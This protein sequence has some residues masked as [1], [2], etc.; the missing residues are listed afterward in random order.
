MGQLTIALAGSVGSG[1]STVAQEIAQRLGCPV[2]G[3]G[4]Y[5]RYLA[6]EAGEATDRLSLQRLGQAE[7][8]ADPTNFVQRFLDWAPLVPSRSLIIDGVRHAAVDEALR[9]WARSA[10]REYVLV[11]LDTPV[12][13]RA[14]R[15]HKGDEG[16]MVRTD[17]HPVERETKVLLPDLADLVVDGSGTVDEVLSRIADAAPEPLARLLHGARLAA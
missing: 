15:R 6:I 2:A 16:A 17:G 5:V 3:F 1:K 14:A 7:I 4:N 13:E 9:T 11:L 10:R 8:E 12:G